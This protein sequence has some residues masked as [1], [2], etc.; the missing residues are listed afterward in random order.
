MTK[1]ETVRRAVAAGLGTLAT[2][3]VIARRHP[4]AAAAIVAAGA[5][6]AWAAF[7]PSAPLFGRT[8]RRGPAHRP[9]AALTFD[10]G[11][12]PSTP[13]VLDAL[14]AEGVRATFFVLGRQARRHPEV[15]RRIRAEGHEV[16]NHGYDHGILLFRDGRHVEDQLAR[17]E[18]AVREATGAAPH[19]LFRAPHGYRG[20][21]T[22]RAAARRGYRMASW[23]RGV[24]DSAE[25]GVDVIAA[26]AARALRPGAVIL[27]HDADGWDPERG[28]AQTAEA[29][30]AICRAARERGIELV[31]LGELV[32]G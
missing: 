17:T 7:V 23:T 28:R 4:A 12:G 20:P 18:D 5:A 3:A 15:V 32:G 21:V 30:P 22:A 1:R 8:I 24:F 29:L 13:A 26:R 10:D 19:P 2:A 14:A 31:P 6:A 9:R 25:P 16:A 27:L 11:P